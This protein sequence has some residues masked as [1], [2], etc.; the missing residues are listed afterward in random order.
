MLASSVAGVI[1]LSIQFN[2]FGGQFS[3]MT[4]LSSTVGMIAF[5]IVVLTMEQIGGLSSVV[6]TDVL[7]G[8]IMVIC[9]VL[10]PFIL[11][12][13]YGFFFSIASA[14]CGN[15]RFFNTSSSEF[16]EQCVAA[17]ADADCAKV[18]CIGNTNPSF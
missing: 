11:W 18:G 10:L 4:G 3:A 6:Y 8:V 7:Q 2:A 15:L 16:A 13:D 17:P 5:G 12:S 1:Y 9:F 14:D